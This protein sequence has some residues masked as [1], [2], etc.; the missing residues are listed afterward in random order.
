MSDSPNVDMGQVQSLAA[1]LRSLGQHSDRA[2]EYAAVKKQLDG[3]SPETVLAAFNHTVEHP[4]LLTKMS[5]VHDAHGRRKRGLDIK[6]PAYQA[7]K[8]QRNKAAKAVQQR[9]FNLSTVKRGKTSRGRQRS[10]QHG[11][12]SA[13][14]DSYPMSRL[15]ADMRRYSTETDLHTI[16]LFRDFTVVTDGTGVHA[17]VYSDDPSGTPDWASYADVFEEYRVLCLQVR[18]RPQW[19]TG[20]GTY[21]QFSPIATA[22]DRSD[23]VA[24]TGYSAAAEFGSM[25]EHAARQGFTVSAPMNNAEEAIFLPTSS[26]TARRWIKMYSSVNTASTVVGHAQVMYLVQFRGTGLT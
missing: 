10:A 7:L 12:F 8:R 2:Q 22:V 11:E 4:T 6:R 14:A 15:S 9:N 25:K 18:F 1:Y 17:G 5:D 24:L 3:M 13:A 20:G 21:V 16:P 23:A 26:T 19:A